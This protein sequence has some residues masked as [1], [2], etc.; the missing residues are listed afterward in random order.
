MEIAIKVFLGFL[1][2]LMLSLIAG[3]ID[4]W[5]EQRKQ[6]KNKRR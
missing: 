4:A 6:K 5:S 1:G 3:F 2:L